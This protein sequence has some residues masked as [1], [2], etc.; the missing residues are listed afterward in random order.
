LTPVLVFVSFDRKH[1][2]QSVRDCFLWA[3]RV[4]RTT[5]LQVAKTFVRR[6]TNVSDPSVIMSSHMCVYKAGNDVVRALSMDWFVESAL[7]Y[8]LTGEPTR[9]LCE[10]NASVASRLNRLQVQW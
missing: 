8:R 10:H 2:K 3:G 4:I 6:S 7:G 9:C 5:H 1:W